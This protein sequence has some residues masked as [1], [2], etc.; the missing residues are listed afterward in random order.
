MAEGVLRHLASDKFEVF[1]AGVN[2]TQL[3]AKAIKVM[4]EIGIDTSKQKSKSI[5][6]FLGQEFDYIITVCDNAKQTCP[7]FPGKYEKM[8]WKLEDPVLTQGAEEKRLKVFRKI[9]NQIKENILKLL[10]L[11]KDKANLKCP[12]CGHIQEVTIPQNSCLHLYQCNSCRKTI[13][14]TSGSCCVICAYSDKTC[15]VFFN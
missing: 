14:P 8:H 13:T 5:K 15:P 1:S 9:R 6:E 3:N 4:S 7:V 2:P 11:P 12:H 10:N